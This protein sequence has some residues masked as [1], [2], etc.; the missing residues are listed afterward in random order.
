[1]KKSVTK[2]EQQYINQLL[3]KRKERELDKA[4]STVFS[5]K[6]FDRERL[7]LHDAEQ[8]IKKNSDGMTALEIQQLNYISEKK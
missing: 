2:Q 4:I 6:H 3:K 1:M 5:S 8:Y 7:S